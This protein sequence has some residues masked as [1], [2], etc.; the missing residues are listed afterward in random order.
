MKRYF[1]LL[2]GTAVVATLAA[3]SAVAGSQDQNSFSNNKSGKTH[4]AEWG[5]TGKNGPEN[6]GKISK[7]YSLCKDGKNQSPI[8]I[9]GFEQTNLPKIDVNY[10][11]SPLNISNNGHTVQVNYNS[12]SNVKIGNKQYNLQQVHFHTPS[13]HAVEGK[14]S[15]MEVHFVHKDQQG[16]LGVIGVLVEQGKENKELQ[17]IWNNIPKTPGQNVSFNN[18]K[19]N[20]EKLIPQNKQY[21][22]YTGSLT[23]PPCSEQVSW[24]VIKQPI[25]ASKQQIKAFKNFYQYNARPQQP[26]KGRQVQGS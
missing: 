18:V 8:N 10:K 11:Q 12:G 5:Y 25:Q 13:E 14:N 16:K 3:T 9:S 26:L 6:W 2:A 4:Q 7:Q 19:V 22:S 1:T 20:A 15:P 23:T 21:F 17:N 24:Y